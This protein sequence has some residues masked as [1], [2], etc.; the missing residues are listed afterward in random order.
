MRSLFN[1]E[2]V[3]K[4]ANE[5]AFAVAIFVLIEVASVALDYINAVEIDHSDP[6]VW[7]AGLAAAF[8]RGALVGLRG[9]IRIVLTRTLNALR[10][11]S[12]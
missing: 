3:W 11:N 12:A 10:G 8:A 6:G 7:F 2:Y 5:T 4:W 9:A 1:F